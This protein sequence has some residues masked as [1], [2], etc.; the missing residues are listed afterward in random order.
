LAFQK[1]ITS[2]MNTV[3]LLHGKNSSFRKMCFRYTGQKKCWSSHLIK[4]AWK[5]AYHLY[6]KIYCD[7]INFFFFLYLSSFSLSL[8]S[9]PL[10]YLFDASFSTDSW[11]WLKHRN[12]KD[13]ITGMK[14]LPLFPLLVTQRQFI[15]TKATLIFPCHYGLILHFYLPFHYFLPPPS[16]F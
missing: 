16:S 11:H 15:T 9:P 6:I 12:K 14:C 8:C 5:K 13:V 2:P 4:F 10:S 3:K 1:I 7:E